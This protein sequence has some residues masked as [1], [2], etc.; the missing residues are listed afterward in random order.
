MAD[1]L[2]V[3]ASLIAIAQ[4]SGSIISLC[5]DYRRGF[6]GAQ[7]EVLQIFRETQSL[8]NV[9]EQ[10]I[11]LVD[12]NNDAGSEVNLPSLKNMS[13]ND[14]PISEF[15]SDL[16]K[17]EDRLRKPVTKWQRLGEQLLWPL[18]ERDV[19]E[20]LGSIHRMKGII[21]FGLVADSTAAIVEI[22]RN[23][24]ELKDRILDYRRSNFHI[25][26][27]ED[28]QVML[29]WLRSPDPSVPHNDVCKKR[30]KD[31]GLWL[32][33]GSEYGVWHKGPTA[34]FWLHGI[35][36]C[37]KS[38]LSSVV[39]EHIKSHNIQ[40]HDAALAYFYFDFSNETTCKSEVMLRSL[41]SQLSMWRGKPPKAL[42]RCARKHFRTTYRSDGDELAVYRDGI[43]QP[44]THD[45][46]EILRGIAEEYDDTYLVVDGLDECL[47][48]GELL[49]IL[50]D[51]LSFQEDGL[52]IFLASRRSGD[53]S[54]VLD[55]KVTYTVE[56]RSEDVGG[57]IYNFVQEQLRT[58]PK[59]SKWPAS[60]RMEIQ[61][62]LISGAGGMFR[63]VHCQLGILGKCITIKNIRKAL[64][65]LPKSLSET[66]ALTIDGIDEDHW[67]Y[68]VKILMWLATSPRPLEIGEAAEVL[69]VD[70]EAEGGP[71]Y[72]EDLRVL[73]P[74]I[75][76]P[77]MCTSLV[78]TTTTCLRGRNGTHETVIELRLAH[79]TVREYLLSEE[80]FLRMRHTALFANKPQVHAFV[81]RTSLAY[82]LSIQEAL[83]EEVQK[84]RP[85]SRH[86]AEV[87]LY[88][89]QEASKETSLELLVLQLLRDNGQTEPYRNWC[90]LFDPSKPWRQPDLQRK[91]CPSPLYYASSEG[92]EPLVLALLK[93]G[94]DCNAVGEIHKT[95]LQAAACNGHIGIVRALLKA[96]ADVNSGGGLYHVP[97]IA[98]SA[99]GHAEIVEVLLEH[100][101]YAN[102]LFHVTALTEASRRNYLEVVRV[103]I[104]GG[105][106]PNQYYSKYFDVN[107]IEA[108]SSRGYKDCVA[109][110]LPKASRMTAR[111]G[112]EEASKTTLDRDMLKIFVEFI[113]D[114]VLNYAAALGYEDLVEDLLGTGAKSETRTP[115]AR[116]LGAE[117][118]SQ[119]ALVQACANGHLG[120]AQQLIDKGADINAKAGEG[121]SVA[122]TM[123]TRACNPE[124]VKLLLTHGANV[125]AGGDDGP[126]L[127][128]AAYEGYKDIVQILIDHGASLE[129]STGIYGGPAQAAVLGDHI[130]ILK[131]V[132]A[133]GTNVNMMAGLS[134]EYISD[135]ALSGSPI[136]AAVFCSNIPMANFLLGHGADPNLWRNV[137]GR[138]G[139]MAPLS[140]AAK[141]GNLDLVNRLLDAGADVKAL[142][143]GLDSGPA[144]FWAVRGGFLMVVN[145]LLDAGADPNATCH[146]IVGGDATILAEACSGKDASVVESMLKAGAD[147]RKYSDFRENNEPP[148]HTAARCG[149]VDVIRLLKKYGA[150]VNEQ[151]EGGETALHKAA[152][153]GRRDIVE[154]LLLEL[155]ADPLLS[156]IKGSLPIHT[157]ASWNS[158]ECLELLVKVSDIN[159]RNKAGRTPLHWAA[160][161]AATKAVEWLLN[162]AADDSAEE[163]GT[164]MTARDYA[165]LRMQEADSGNN[166]EY[167]EVLEMFDR[168]LKVKYA[169]R[170]S[171]P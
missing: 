170:P 169:I 69:A 149:S 151:C 159:A 89:Y 112:L 55:S 13:A 148:I 157:A 71:V 114:D 20:A 60:L 73:D 52:R 17:L 45:L 162:N 29:E 70:L 150:D 138:K 133:A 168:H 39:I 85:L 111:G 97:I 158:P 79:Y 56:A 57:D 6:Q 109:L 115:I 50:D 118:C 119:S 131:I 96:G 72:D 142:E 2:S 83:T 107:P 101:A 15:Q 121:S 145:R 141:N 139:M 51:I 9:I 136:Q 153:G 167:A 18:R 91:T 140:M 3:A 33:D 49:E 171:T 21:E 37:G 135:V 137:N 152:K 58:H 76:I 66:Y 106:S 84:D 54:A 95:G 146:T 160:D 144:L 61:D 30:A 68:A 47:D 74:T 130:D 10:L 62:S 103:L 99:S 125:N 34:S 1:P 93:A 32:L 82:I 98:A 23:T 53:I 4:V 123:A 132:L 8:R 43:P 25:S 108:A 40:I 94:A 81:A 110:M 155:Q 22:Q 63:W 42:S 161:H 7:K 38:V 35:P 105:A 116:S 27:Q 59:L 129:D 122:L 166:A 64:K 26:E 14:G 86:A 31:S 124:M 164:N 46:V 5:Y 126:A 134:T 11:H 24:R 102:Y 41:V 19:K 44:T 67:E 90:K 80:F 16:Q 87:W 65:A 92:L 156:L 12:D 117:D 48:Q 163:F 127:Q 88:H 36:G 113:P 165:E 104:N 128:I 75:E 147:V 143:E 78:A 120:I 28:L 154:V 77:A 100:G